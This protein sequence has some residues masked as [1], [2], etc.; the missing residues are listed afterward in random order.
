MSY[1]EDWMR[2]KGLSESSI[3][4]YEG[5]ITGMMTQWAVENSIISGSL[6]DIT[7]LGE[8]Q[9]VSA[10]SQYAA[11]LQESPSNEIEQDID[12]IIE[13]NTL[14]KTEKSALIKARIGQGPFR[15]KL[16]TT[17]NVALLRASPMLNCS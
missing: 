12:S 13:S 9:S 5:A 16:S 15:G 10:L 6:A 7:N 3:L 11:Y 8:F 4:K 1:F 14:S 2:Q 17:G